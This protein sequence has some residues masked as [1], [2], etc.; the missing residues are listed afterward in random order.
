MVCLPTTSVEMVNVASATPPT[1]WIVPV[2]TTV[3]PSLK[4]TVPVGKPAPGATTLSLAVKVTA[5]PELT[6]LAEALTTVLVPALDTA[7]ASAADV[8]I[9]KL[10]SPL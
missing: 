10:L 9:L 3:E 1:T 5:C 7:R 6:D 2:P 8:L 4:V